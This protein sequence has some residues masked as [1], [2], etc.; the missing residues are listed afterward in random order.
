MTVFGDSD[1]ANSLRAAFAATAAPVEPPK[2]SDWATSAE[3]DAPLSLAAL[4]AALGCDGCVGG[5]VN[6]YLRACGVEPNYSEFFFDPV[7]REDP[8]AFQASS[9]LLSLRSAHATACHCF[10]SAATAASP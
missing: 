5:A 1:L 9:A 10:C 8:N 7:Y 2:P 3:A 6:A 4:C